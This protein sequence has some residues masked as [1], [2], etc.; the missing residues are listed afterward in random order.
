MPKEVAEIERGNS[1]SY[2]AVRSKLFYF[3]QKN[4]KY[5]YTLRELVDIFS[6]EYKN[7]YSHE[8][9]LYKLISDYL[10]QL[11]LQN[12]IKHK[13]NFYYFKHEEKK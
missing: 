1:E 12:K 11:R 7:K 9:V 8:K 4:H 5:G 2:I 13:G 3:L 10:G 6:K